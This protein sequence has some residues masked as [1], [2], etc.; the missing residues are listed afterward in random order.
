MRVD[1]CSCACQAV[2][3]ISPEGHAAQ[4]A[5]LRLHELRSLRCASNN[6]V[7]SYFPWRSRASSATRFSAMGRTTAKNSSIV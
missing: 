6:R 1:G 5:F 3:K 2:R 4:A 7:L